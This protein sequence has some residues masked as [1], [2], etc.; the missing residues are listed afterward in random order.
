[1]SEPRDRYLVLTSHPVTIGDETFR[2]RVHWAEVDGRATVVGIDLR[3]FFSENEDAML[4]DLL[5]QDDVYP[6]PQNEGMVEITTRALRGL[7][8]REVTEASRQEAQRLARWAPVVGGEQAERDGVVS[9]LEPARGRGGPPRTIPDEALARVV[10]P[11]YLRAGSNTTEAVVAAL[12]A[13]DLPNLRN[14]VS[15][16]QA[17]KAIGRAREL[18][19][20]PP[21]EKKG[22]P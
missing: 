8:L 22:K 9:A 4:R 14:L 10:A 15:V 2:V 21:V 1:M 7:G 6:L 18:G 16:N 3:A 13:A 12:R 20:I 11:A 17:K 19:L 5:E